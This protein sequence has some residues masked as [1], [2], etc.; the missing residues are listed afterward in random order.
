MLLEWSTIACLQVCLC[1]CL[2]VCC[3]RERLNTLSQQSRARQ[4]DQ[5]SSTGGGDRSPRHQEAG[6]PTGDEATSGQ[7]ARE[8]PLT[9]QPAGSK[10]G[11]SVVPSLHQP[12]EDSGGAPPLAVAN[13]LHQTPEDSEGD[14]PHAILDP[15][16]YPPGDSGGDPPLAI[17]DS[18]HQQL[19]DSGEGPPQTIL[20][21]LRYPPQVL[22]PLHQPADYATVTPSHYQMSNNSFDNFVI[23][24]HRKVVSRV[25]Y[26]SG[27]CSGQHAMQ[28]M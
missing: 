17:A 2:P 19:G 3:R 18:V 10:E 15:L 20:D 9:R 28:C 1:V 21:P 4:K 12:P 24:M 13:P 26:P 27:A 25:L 5:S 7:E 16:R 6:Q 14:P 22:E 8:D 11:D 23:A